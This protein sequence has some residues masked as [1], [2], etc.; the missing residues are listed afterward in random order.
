MPLSGRVF[1]WGLP[2]N[3][4]STIADLDK[5]SVWWKALTV[6]MKAIGMQLYLTFFIKK[7]KYSL[8][9]ERGLAVADSDESLVT[10]TFSLTLF[11]PHDNNLFISTE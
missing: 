11:T 8:L 6:D 1:K 5:A 10:S 9:A 4:R 3:R 7:M 2:R